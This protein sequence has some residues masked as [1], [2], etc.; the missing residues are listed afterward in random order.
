[1][2]QADYER[3]QHACSCDATRREL[4]VAAMISGSLGGN[5]DDVVSHMEAHRLF[6]VLWFPSPVSH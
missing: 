6:A 1:M 3:Y 4:A 5:T 2:K